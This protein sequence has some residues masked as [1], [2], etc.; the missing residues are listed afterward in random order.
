MSGGAGAGVEASPRKSERRRSQLEPSLAKSPRERDERERRARRT[1]PRV[2]RHKSAPGPGQGPVEDYF[3]ARNGGG[4]G[5]S[6]SRSRDP[7]VNGMHKAGTDHTSSWVNSQI[8]EPPAPP[9]ITPTL[10][11]GSPP[12][13]STRTKDRERERGGG[14]R[15]ERERDSEEEVERE[16]RQRRRDREARRIERDATTSGGARRRSD[17]GGGG[18][19][20]DERALKRRSTALKRSNTDYLARGGVDAGYAGD[21]ADRDKRSSWWKGLGAKA[22]I[23]GL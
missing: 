20:P 21:R 19:S 22:K 6:A 11:D 18:G 17:G 3:D 5:A 4:A 1:G 16:R 9:P 10:V 2:E 14:A 12:R 13:T 23:P 15:R 7:Y 8:M